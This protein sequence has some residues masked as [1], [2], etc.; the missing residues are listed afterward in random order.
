MIKETIEMEKVQVKTDEFV[1]LDHFNQVAK[2]WWVVALALFAGGLGGFLFHQIQKPIYEATATFYVTIDN[3]KMPDLRSLPK[4]QY[5][6][7]EDLALSSTQAM[8]LSP[9]VVQ[10]VLDESTRLNNPTDWE[11]LLIHDSQIERRHA[12][13][14]LHYRNSDP[15]KAQA[16]ANFWAQKGYEAMI[17]Q[18]K[19]GAIVPFVLF[20]PPSPAGLP[21]RP[22]LYDRNKVILAGAMIGLIPGIL[23]ADIL[24]G[25]KRRANRAAG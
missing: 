6:Y 13:W 12:F 17:A 9:E 18:Q 25:K 3:N 15:L 11:T 10:A 7:N 16:I 21:K 4:D 14:L 8:L 5:Q 1:L 24:A 2:L 23:L 20:S 19:A 22:V